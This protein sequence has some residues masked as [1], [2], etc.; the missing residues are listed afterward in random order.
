M[1][2]LSRKHGGKPYDVGTVM[3]LYESAW[4]QQNEE[5]IINSNFFQTVPRFD[6]VSHLE[7]G[8]YL[9]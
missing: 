3:E 5:S 2:N 4:R 6:H 9:I 1:M 7:A 8:I